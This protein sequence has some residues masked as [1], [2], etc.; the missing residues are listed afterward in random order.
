[1]TALRFFAAGLIVLHHFINHFE[2]GNAIN[3]FFPTHQAVSFFFVLS[4]F[5]LTYV[6]RDFN[7]PGSVRRFF[8]ARFARVWPLHCAT[9]LLTLFIIAGWYS[10]QSTRPGS[11]TSFWL[12]LLSNLLLVQS[13]IPL[14]K[15]YYS[16]N[17]VSWSISTEFGFYLMFPLLLAGFKHN[18]PYKLIGTLAFTILV[19]LSL[20]YL[21]I[22]DDATVIG[23]VGHL[24]LAR[25]FEFTAGMTT[26][27]LYQRLKHLYKP[28][29]M[30]ANLI[31]AAALSGV[32]LGMA[33]SIPLCFYSKSFFATPG[34]LWVLVGNF[35]VIFIAPFILVMAL[36]QG[37]ISRFLSRP[38]FVFLGE[39]SFSIYL[40]HQILLRAYSAYF[41]DLIV[42]PKWLIFGYFIA[43]VLLSSYLLWEFIE[44]PCRKLILDWGARR[45]PTIRDD[46]LAVIRKKPV[47]YSILCLLI[48]SAPLAGSKPPGAQPCF[49]M[50][51]EAQI[52]ETLNNSVEGL[53]NIH[54]GKDFSLQGVVVDLDTQ[55]QMKLLWESLANTRL[56]HKVAVHFLDQRKEIVFQGD[57]FQSKSRNE[58][59]RVKKNSFWI[60]NVDLTKVSEN[61]AFIGL[62]LFTESDMKLLPVSG[63]PRDW[64]NRRLLIPLRDLRR[65]ER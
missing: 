1:M 50:A 49:A 5:I 21:A 10:Q 57:Y 22:N 38:G 28:G 65:G 12:P 45:R 37:G 51:K 19:A 17:A 47:Q 6:Y 23:I 53:R 9:L 43:L 48:L 40:L 13:W 20:H 52:E 30:A 7:A 34:K 64:N 2:F 61:I 18:W 63:G 27:L 25:L 42:A 54:F 14:E 11:L 26:A 8:I 59:C 33:M 41:K 39:I 32:L 4:G 24:P 29:G 44:K 3:R 31:E 60:D 16:F 55:N 15:F 62:A 36:R 46:L 58:R 35:S 56:K